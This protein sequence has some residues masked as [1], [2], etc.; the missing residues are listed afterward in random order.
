M[1]AVCR[2]GMAMV[3]YCH[4]FVERG[5]AVPVGATRILRLHTGLSFLDWPNDLL[6]RISAPQGPSS[7][8]TDYQNLAGR[9]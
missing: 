3:Q 2:F 4:V 6:I 9:M 5:I 7:L 1:G 8:G